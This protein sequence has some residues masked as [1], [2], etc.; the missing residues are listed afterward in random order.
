[1]LHIGQTEIRYG[2]ILAPMAGFTDA[3]MR[4]VCRAFGAEYTVTEM[5]SAKAVVYGDRKT[6]ALARI[7]EDEMPCAVQLFGAQEDILARAAERMARGTPGGV[8]PVAID[9]NMGCPVPKVYG[10]GEGS[11]LMRDPEKIRRIVH[12]VRGAC[13]LPCTVKIRSGIDEKH[14]LAVE[15]ALAAEA[16]GAAAIAVHGRT[17]NQLYNGK[18]DR[19]IIR[20]V[21]QSVHIPV[22][23]NGDVDSVESAMSMFAECGVDAVM[24]G[25]GAIGN[26]FLFREIRCA[27]TA[28]AY[29]PPTVQQRVSCALAQLSRAIADKG[30]EVAVR[31]CRKQIAR[32]LRA[33]AGCA[34]VRGRIHSARTYDQVCD[35][36]WEYAQTQD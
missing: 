25:R 33:S 29:T 6:G 12:A 18:A 21:K 23:G 10:N 31:E 22:I 28:E 11:A 2:L 5:V 16:G 26:P 34:A 27:M 3:A 24:I 8:A 13:G 7:R 30:E 35:V 32:Y 17:R 4:A 19:N 36:M 15:C 9:L 14:I 20:K 1:M